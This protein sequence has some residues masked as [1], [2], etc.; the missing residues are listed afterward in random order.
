[1]FRLQEYQLRYV[2][3]LVD[4]ERLDLMNELLSFQ[5]GYEAVI[6]MYPFIL[7]SL[8]LSF[9]S[10]VF[11]PFGGFFASGFKRAFKI[12]VRIDS[13]DQELSVSFWP[14]KLSDIIHWSI[15]L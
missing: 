11:A 1:L 4:W 5:A 6:A 12:K 2:S 14:S 13:W 3:F 9:F 8:V 7:H 15:F 10:S